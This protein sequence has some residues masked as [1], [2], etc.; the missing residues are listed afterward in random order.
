MTQSSWV[1]LKLSALLSLDKLSVENS[2]M[3]GITP[4][5]AIS[6]NQVCYYRP[7]G[8]AQSEAG[9][10]KDRQHRPTESERMRGQKIS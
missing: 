8:S 7:N 2:M 6:V 10:A 1:I 3:V 4:S 5:P 9:T